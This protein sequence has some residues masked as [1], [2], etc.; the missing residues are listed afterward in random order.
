[1]G[2]RRCRWWPPLAAVMMMFLLS[3]FP[4][5]AGEKPGSSKHK[6]EDAMLRDV[7]KKAIN[8]GAD[9]FDFNRDAAGCAGVYE[10][11]L[12]TIRPMLK[13]HP[14]LQKKV[15]QALADAKA[16]TSPVQ[17]AFRLN[18]ALQDIRRTLGG[19]K[20]AP[21]G[22]KVGPPIEKKGP[23]TET[24]KTLWDRLGGEAGVRKVVDDFV[25]RAAADK[26]V[27]FT[28][29]GE[30]K[31][32]VPKL[33]QHLVDFVSQVTGGPRR[34]TGPSMK[35]VH[36]GMHITN[37]EFDRSVEDLKKVL[38]DNHVPADAA[39]DLLKLVESTRK[40]FVEQG[41][42]KKK[43][44]EKTPTDKTGEKKGTEKEVRPAGE[45]AS[46]SGRVNFKG[47]P[48]PG[49]SIAFLNASGGRF[50]SL[51]HKDGS[52]EI[53]SLPAGTYRVVVETASL[54]PA[55][56]TPE[57]IKG[58]TAPAN[59]PGGQTPVYVA[60]SPRY[61]MPE[62]TPLTAKLLKGRQTLDFELQ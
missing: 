61:S 60:I 51:I 39:H 14:K 11:A 15:D 26:R 54:K 45:K 19:K 53:K 40:Q 33:K 20:T 57:K 13:H 44:K 2:T 59:P 31:V 17:R 36:K 23:P 6:A 43:E 16:A 48:L 55:S 42:T 52:Y 34:Y 12:I 37:K 24:K 21:G 58:G 5:A 47:R 35:E 38:K 10:G 9:L 28:R 27:D 50:R 4:A 56:K 25:K 46:V 32:D 22:E 30:W 7:L 62:T 29:N 8:R 41:T 1:M 3:S 49:G 18:A